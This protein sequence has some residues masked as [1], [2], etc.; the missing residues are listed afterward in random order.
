M[1]RGKQ[2]MTTK[3]SHGVRIV[4]ISDETI[5]IPARTSVMHL[6][7]HG[8][9]PSGNKCVRPDS[10]KYREW[11]LEIYGCLL[12]P[13][14]EEQLDNLVNEFNWSLPAAVPRPRY[15]TPTQILKR[16]TMDTSVK[17]CQ[18]SS[19]EPEQVFH[20]DAEDLDVGDASPE[21]DAG[22]KPARL[23]MTMN[24]LTTESRVEQPPRVSDEAVMNLAMCYRALATTPEPGISKFDAEVYFHEGEDQVLLESLR[25][26][27][28]MLPEIHPAEPVNLDEADVGEP[29]NTP[30][31]ME[32]IRQILRKHQSVF[33]SSGN[34]LPPPARGVV[35]DIEIEPGTKPIAQK[36][37]R[38][39]SHQLPKVAELLKGLLQNGIIEP[40]NS[41]WASPI[42]IV[43]KKNGVDIR[44]CI[45]YRRVNQL[46]N[47]MAY[48][49]PLI[50]ELLDDFDAIMWFLSL[51]MASGFWAILMTRRAK[52]ISAFICPLGHFQWIRMPFG[53]KNAP[54]IYQRVIDNCLW[55][56]VRLPPALEAEV[57][58]EVLAGVGIANHGQSQVSAPKA[59]VPVDEK[60][61]FD[62]NI[63]APACMGSVLGRSSYIDDIAYG[64]TTWN[65]LCEILDKLLYRLRYWGISVSLPKS[66]FGKMLIQYLSHEIS[67][68]GIRATPKILK[69]IENLVFPDTLKGVQSFLGSLN[70]Y[71][72]FIEGF[73]AIATVLYELT[74]E[75][76]RSGR[77][78]EK[79]KK[80]F[81]LL[82]I[83]IQQLPG[84]RH[85]DRTK[86]FTVPTP[87]PW[88]RCWLRCTMVNCGRSDLLAVR[89]KTQSFAIMKRRRKS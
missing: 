74:D 68:L 7:E 23:P 50:D 81:E 64:A 52:E 47:L 76:V 22:S 11:Q 79:A 56:F 1:C 85:A 59:S 16:S 19:S 5:H 67:R 70:Y 28:T 26:Q 30:E 6:V 37:R 17:S 65:Q 82:K 63:P 39:P 3:L 31:E 75:Q 71:H 2:W 32:Q 46:I 42:V 45:D 36:A 48:P 25:E 89:S 84:L 14:R 51:D 53:L 43:M 77:D 86:P 49:L 27:L 35:C 69:G 72:K 20:V 38:I 80:A 87:G 83:R 78:L 62:L 15:I 10:L 29:E 34:A 44:L 66:A 54:L 55:G 21:P 73:P 24:L 12:S 18:T 58:P 9:L 40:S 8:Q 57:E 88:A 60:T 41:K 13:E 61:V 4:N 33:I